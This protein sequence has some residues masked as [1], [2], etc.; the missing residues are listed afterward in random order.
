MLALVVPDFG[1]IATEVNPVV[2]KMRKPGWRVG[3]LSSHTAAETPQLYWSHMWKVGPPE[4][5][6]REVRQGLG[7]CDMRFSKEG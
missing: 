1:M 7:L 3:G 5:L 6:A 4:P 2:Q